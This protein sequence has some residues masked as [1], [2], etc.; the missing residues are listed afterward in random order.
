MSTSN[1]LHSKVGRTEWV[2]ERFEGD[3]GQHLSERLL[4]LHDCPLVC[5]GGCIPGMAV[6]ERVA[7]ELVTEAQ[8]FRDIFCPEHRPH[9]R[10]L[11]HK[12]Q[13]CVVSAPDAMSRQD[14]AGLK[15]CR[16]R[17][18]VEGKGDEG[19]RCCHS[20]APAEQSPN[21][22]HREPMSHS[23]NEALRH[24]SGANLLVH[25]LGQTASGAASVALRCAGPSSRSSVATWRRGP[26][27]QCNRMTI[28][29]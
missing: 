26:Q 7:S 12:A 16:L 28:P 10:W 27:P 8:N 29:R 6:P 17:E 24:H 21:C 23:F 20:K 18:V 3:A 4:V 15:E 2:S 11:S 9:R 5:F 1:S 13:R 14:R 19:N 22:F 25:V